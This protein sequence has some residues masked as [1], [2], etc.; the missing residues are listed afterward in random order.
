MMRR[1]LLCAGLQRR[2]LACQGDGVEAVGLS[3][4]LA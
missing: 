2:P 3:E 4:R 1:L